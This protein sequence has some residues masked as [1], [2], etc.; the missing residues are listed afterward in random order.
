VLEFAIIVLLSAC[1]ALAFKL[2][3][4][5]TPKSTPADARTIRSYQSRNNLF[6]NEAER[7]LFLALK[8]SA[9]AH[10]QVFSKVRLEDIIAVR[11]DIKDRRLHWQYRGRIKSRHVD[12]LICDNG[13]RFICAIELDGRSHNDSNV[14]MTD[15]FKDAIFTHIGLKLYRVRVGEDFAR[16]STKIWAR[17][18]S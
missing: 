8:G 9:P 13:G 5:R 4:W 16:F 18:R 12:F 3:K 1:A 11:S 14:Q 7:A 6:V 2:G 17:M 10:F 15:S